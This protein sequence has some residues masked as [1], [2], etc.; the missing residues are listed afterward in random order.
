MAN[1]QESEKSV[2]LDHERVS[3][4]GLELTVAPS[5]LFSMEN[6]RRVDLSSNELT[7][8]PGA[9][10]GRELPCLEVL[11]L[12]NNLLHV[13]EDILALACAPRL[14][15]LDVRSNPLR[16]S[17]NRL[18]LLESLLFQEADIDEDILRELHQDESLKNYASVSQ[19]SRNSVYRSRLPRRRGFP[20][21]QMLNGDWISDSESRQVEIE[22]GKRLEF[23]QPRSCGSKKG[24]IN[25]RRN[26][27]KTASADRIKVNERRFD[28]S[29]MTIKQMVST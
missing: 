1:Q 25:A 28:G 23:Y 11:V 16:L 6:T 8:F 24:K 9:R 17:H 13:L 14:C 22:R 12:S 18:Y 20:V 4:R 26:N 29:R 7:R 21:L 10:V 15:E 5:S 19:R 2:D 27:C 3:F